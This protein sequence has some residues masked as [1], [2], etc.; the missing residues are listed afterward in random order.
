MTMM[1]CYAAARQYPTQSARCSTLQVVN[2]EIGK[3]GEESVDPRL[4]DEDIQQF[5]KTGNAGGQFIAAKSV[6]VH[7][8][9]PS[10]G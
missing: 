2:N 1:P 9:P 4:I 5:R 6:G 7:L 8:Q 3:V 10:L